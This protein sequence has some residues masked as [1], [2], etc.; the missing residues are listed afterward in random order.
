MEERIIYSN[1]QIANPK[2]LFVM[3]DKV[4]QHDNRCTLIQYHVQGNS[5][6]HDHLYSR[7]AHTQSTERMWQKCRATFMFAGY[8]LQS[9]IG[10][11]GKVYLVP[12]AWSNLQFSTIQYVFQTGKDRMKSHD[13]ERLAAK[14]TEP[15]QPIGFSK[16]REKSINDRL[17]R[18][19][20]QVNTIPQLF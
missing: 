14:S 4:E 11:W 16:E 13:L 12:S 18:I 1:P 10:K 20:A 6:K 2:F 17:K 3:I 5:F 19:A 15:S 9:V 8:D 7:L